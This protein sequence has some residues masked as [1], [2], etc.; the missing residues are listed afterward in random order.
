MGKEVKECGEQDRS[1]WD[2]VVEGVGSEFG[3][4][5]FT[6]ALLPVRK[7]ASHFLSLL[8]RFVLSIFCVSMCFG[9]VSQ[10]LFMSIAVRRVRKGWVFG[11]KPSIIV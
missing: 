9:T 11:F 3:G 5:I 7:F 4:S 8:G 1:L 6:F 10:A 2:T